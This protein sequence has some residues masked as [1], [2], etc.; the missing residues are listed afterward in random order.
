M[1]RLVDYYKAVT[2]GSVQ[3][4]DNEQTG[5]QLLQPFKAKKLTTMTPKGC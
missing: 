2:T 3:L 5:T 1:Q 4:K